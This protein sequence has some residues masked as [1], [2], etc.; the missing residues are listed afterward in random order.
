MLDRKMVINELRKRGYIAEEKNIVKN[1]VLC[2]GISIHLPETKM[3]NEK[4]QS[5]FGVIYMDTLE[6]MKEMERLNAIIAMDIMVRN[7]N[8]ESAYFTWIYL[9]PDCANEYD[10]IDFAKNEEG[11]EKNKMFDATV[12]LFKKL[13]EQYASKDDGLYIG[14]K[15]Y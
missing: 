1:G 4:V 9:V 12:A 15:T 5:V 14:N 8:N 7:M 2:D 3:E 11:T 6:E 10:F 13:W